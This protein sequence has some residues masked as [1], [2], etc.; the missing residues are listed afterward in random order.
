MQYLTT[1]IGTD[2]IE[3][4]LSPANYEE[5]TTGIV[6]RPSTQE[7]EE[8]E[9][10]SSQSLTALSP[11][12]ASQIQSVLNAIDQQYNVAG[13]QEPKFSDVPSHVEVVEKIVRQPIT[14]GYD[15]SVTEIYEESLSEFV[16]NLGEDELIKR[17]ADINARTAI[18]LNALNS[19]SNDFHEKFEAAE[20]LAAMSQS[21]TQAELQLN[22]TVWG[23]VLAISVGVLLVIVLI[24]VVLRVEVHLRQ[25]V[26]NVHQE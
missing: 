1:T 5:L 17:I 12:I 7:T 3:D 6:P 25:L 11:Q 2:D 13:R 20:S 14:E 8:S 24:L 26:N 23:W 10:P 15:E 21:V 9:E 22:K 18:L 16:S 19:F 4:F